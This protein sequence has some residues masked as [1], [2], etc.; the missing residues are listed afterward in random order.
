MNTHDTHVDKLVAEYIAE[1][2][3][4]VGDAETPVAKLCASSLG[5]WTMV[6][7]AAKN[8]TKLKTYAQLRNLAD[9]NEMTVKRLRKLVGAFE[10]GE[11][12][13]YS[14]FMAAVKQGCSRDLKAELN[15][16]EIR[17]FKA[18]GTLDATLDATIAL[19]RYDI[20]WTVTA[21]YLSEVADT[22]SPG[23]KRED[24]AKGIAMVEE[25]ARTLSECDAPLR[26]IIRA[27]VATFPEEFRDCA[28]EAAAMA[29]AIDALKEP[30]PPL[31]MYIW[32]LMYGDQQEVRGV[33]GQ[34]FDAMVAHFQRMKRGAEKVEM[35]RVLR[36]AIE[37]CGLDED[38]VRA[39]REAVPL[40][41]VT[42]N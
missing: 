3:V 14:Q 8:I 13:T 33:V 25:C 34:L 35:Q 1:G 11:V 31:G 26:K 22:V 23:S 29:C 21:G 2:R 12:C 30:N 27:E 39:W 41:P 10:S 42:A 20:A 7:F 5:D 38:K 19:L 15:T 16:H 6:D 40:P 4:V 36:S 24:V 17:E 32:S 18:R 37:E 9:V 28:R